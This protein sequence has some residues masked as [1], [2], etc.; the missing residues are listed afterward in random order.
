M[1]DKKD[2]IKYFYY[3]QKHNIHTQVYIHKNYNLSLRADN[4]FLSFFL[5]VKPAFALIWLLTSFCNFVKNAV[6]D[7]ATLWVTSTD[8]VI[9]LFLVSFF[10]NSAF[11]FFFFLAIPGFRAFSFSFFSITCCLAFC[12]IFFRLLSR[13]LS[14]FVRSDLAI[15]SPCDL[16]RNKDYGTMI[17]E[18]T[19]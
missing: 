2:A 4:A 7:F 17:K 1:H 9:F 13:L 8:F 15:R 14:V 10:S 19:S 5:D 3:L 16:A 18:Y 12:L 6:E 11:S